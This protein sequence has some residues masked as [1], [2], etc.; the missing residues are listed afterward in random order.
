MATVVLL[1]C[2]TS[3]KSSA[4]R[5]LREIYG[6]ETEIIDTDAEVA[7]DSEFSGHLYAM[8][9]KFTKE[10]DNSA[11][12][13]FLELGER[14]LLQHLAQKQQTMLIAAGPNIPLREPEWSEFLERVNPI[15]LYFKLSPMQ[16]YEG[17]RQRRMRQKRKGL[18]L[19]PGFGCWDAGLATAYN[20]QTEIWDELP[21]ESALP[22]IETYMKKVEPIY[23]S[24]CHA[25][26]VYDGHAIKTDKAL[27]ENVSRQISSCLRW[28]PIDFRI[29]PAIV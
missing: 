15:C 4:V 6:G 19:C 3:G 14:H 12:Q 20:S 25:G 21:I 18:D 27:Q 8:Y 22:L 23:L 26:S 16:F 9:L 1:G 5:R 17:L 10:G 24:A 28:A 7:A 11:A 2:S 29:E 13:L